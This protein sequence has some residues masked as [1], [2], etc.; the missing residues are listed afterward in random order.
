MSGMTNG[1]TQVPTLANV[2]HRAN[3]RV[4]LTAVLL[5]GVSLFALSMI[6]LRFYMLDNLAL[7]AR[8][9]AYAVEAAVVFDDREA[10][11]E[12]LE[13][14]VVNR[15]V[16]VVYVFNSDGEEVARW[17]GKGNE[18]WGQASLEKLVAAVFFPR[19]AIEAIHHNGHEI[20]V[21]E[22]HNSGRDL[23]RFVL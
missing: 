2:L 11:A 15:P 13:Q 23:A 22:L 6:A 18:S 12:A 16:S 19:P 8:S 21:V 4:V 14:M 1:Q 10:A 5:A 20:G 17:Q 3:L 7:S 9:V